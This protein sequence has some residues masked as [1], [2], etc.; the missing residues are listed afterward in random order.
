VNVRF[1]SFLLA[2]SMST[3]AAAADA[4]QFLY[5]WTDKDGKTQYSDQIPKVPAS[6]VTRIEIDTQ[7][8]PIAGPAVRPGE[9][10]PSPADIAAKRRATRNALELKVA[11]ARDKRDQA[12]AALDG[13]APEDT[14]KQVIQQR[15]DHENPGTGPGS[16]S[17]GGMLGQGG[18]LGAAP[19]MNCREEGKTMI[20]P[21]TVPSE[22]YYERV[23]Q[24]EDDLRKAE[25]ELS[26]AEQAYRRG[27]D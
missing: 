27:V 17:T 13:A 21:T 18:M 22:S 23:Q 16:R 14:E 11:K 15:Q 3:A 25:Q 10:A 1:A 6:E 12:R 24:L 26:V 19:R 7:P 5:K 8:T 4:P 2:V 20:C 9:P